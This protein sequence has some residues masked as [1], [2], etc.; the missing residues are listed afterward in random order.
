MRV[1]FLKSH[2]YLIYSSIYLLENSCRICSIPREPWSWNNAC[3]KKANKGKEGQSLEQSSWSRAGQEADTLRK[4]GKWEHGHRKQGARK[5]R[6]SHLGIKGHLAGHL[7]APRREAAAWVGFRCEE[8]EGYLEVTLENVY[9]FSMVDGI[10]II[11]PW[12]YPIVDAEEF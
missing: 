10:K 2:L 9:L 4:L 1:I 3:F 12:H 7:S 11:A 5:P 8:K 6:G